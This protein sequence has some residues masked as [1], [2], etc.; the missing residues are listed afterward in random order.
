MLKHGYKC[1]RNCNGFIT[2]S[3]WIKNSNSKFRD[4][5]H[6]INLL[7]GE[8]LGYLRIHSQT[9]FQIFYTDHYMIDSG[10]LR[11]SLIGKCICNGS[12]NLFKSSSTC[13][14]LSLRALYRFTSSPIFCAC[15][16]NPNKV[17]RSKT[18]GKMYS[19]EVKSKIVKQINIIPCV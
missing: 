15:L 3:I 9:S 5:W 10:Y 4:K 11:S 16:W 8:L 2:S 17:W 18:S 1:L 14:R 6:L 7:K 12:L 19:C 13:A